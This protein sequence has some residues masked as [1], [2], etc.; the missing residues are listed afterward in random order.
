MARLCGRP[1]QLL[2][3]FPVP[4]SAPLTFAALATASVPSH[5]GVFGCKG[6]SKSAMR[7]GGFWGRGR[8]SLSCLS[9]RFSFRQ[10]VQTVTLAAPAIGF[11]VVHAVGVF[12]V[13]G[14]AGGAVSSRGVVSGK[15]VAAQAVHLGCDGFQ[16]V[17]V[18]TRSVSTQVIELESL[19]D[20]PL[21]NSVGVAVRGDLG[22]LLVGS[23]P[24]T[25]V[26]S[27]FADIPCPV[28]ALPEVGSMGGNRA[29]FV[30]FPK[31]TDLGGYGLS[32]NIHYS[33]K[34]GK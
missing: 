9:G 22:I 6:M 25:A 33:R 13:V 12:G 20:V 11:A 28:P 5:V 14:V 10:L 29:V 24:E 16:V 31:E 3:S 23:M 21:V 32:H 15:R 26:S 34:A 8:N 30:N 19:G 17:G 18:H 7:G 4:Q 27:L 2:S 1:S